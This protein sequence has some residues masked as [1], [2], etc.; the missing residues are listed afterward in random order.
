M[1]HTHTH[2]HI[3]AD[4]ACY[5]STAVLQTFLH[6]NTCIHASMRI[7]VHTYVRTC[8]DM[9]AHTYIYTHIQI[10][11]YIP[12]IHS[13]HTHINNE[14]SAGTESLLAS[15]SHLRATGRFIQVDYTH[16]THIVCAL[17]VCLLQGDSFR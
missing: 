11:T 12:Y 17:S 2:M 3:C 7:H 13:V 5:V 14:R 8:I 15:Y 1:T 9:Y 6:V 10:Y 16:I 4:K